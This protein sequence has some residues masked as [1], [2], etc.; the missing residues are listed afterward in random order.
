MSRRARGKKSRARAGKS[1]RASG[2]P[3]RG[4]DAKKPGE[5]AD[6]QPVPANDEPTGA[7]ADAGSSPGLAERASADGIASHERR[8]LIFIHVFLA[9]QLLLP[10]SYYT[11][12]SDHN[13]ERF[14]WRM[15]SSIR[16]TTC[17]VEFRTGPDQ[18][19]V[20]NLHGI[21]HEAWLGLARRGRQ[22]VINAM[23]QHLCQRSRTAGDEEGGTEAPEVRATVVCQ[24]LVGEP[25]QLGGSW[26]LCRLGAL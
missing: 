5:R 20:R 12:R 8:A 4:P 18:S 2:T 13:D 11:V 19:P 9:L 16:M 23:A 6:S 14:A 22:S 24:P 26:N 15:F 25:E 21:F 10:L 17:Q 7:S 1:R 3:P